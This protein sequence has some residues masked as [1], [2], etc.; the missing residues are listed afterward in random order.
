MQR[1]T[2]E[3]DARGERGKSAVRKLR[4]AGR[5]PGVLYGRGIEPLAISVD[6]RAVEAA[7]QR[8]A[9]ANVLLDVLVREDGHVRTELAMLQDVQRDVLTRRILHVDLHR[10]SLT[11]KVYTR[12]P[13]RLKGEPPGVRE[14]GILEFLRHEVEVTGLPTDLPDHL[15]LDV[16]RLALGDSLHV[17]DLKVPPGVTVLTPPEETLVTVLAPAVAPEEAP[18]A[19]EEVPAQP[20]VV[21]KGKAAEEGEE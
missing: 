21:G 18:A 14:G 3:V 6:A 1:L 12:L 9:G 19:A 17:R 13:V 4:R 5:V 2:L 20:E 8:L 11:E 16:S 7:L 10:I 15:E